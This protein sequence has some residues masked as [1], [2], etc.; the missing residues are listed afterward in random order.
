MSHWAELDDDNVVIR[1]LVGDNEDP[2]GDEGYSWLI[3][4]LGGKWVKTSIHGNIRKVFAGYLYI[5][6][7]V[8]DVFYQPH[9]YG[10]VDY[11]HTLCYFTKINE[12]GLVVQIDTISKNQIDMNDQ[13]QSGIEIL[14][15]KYGEIFTWKQ[16]K[17]NPLFRKNFA[18]VGF[19]YDAELD[20][21]IPPKP[22][23]DNDYNWTFDN[24]EYRWV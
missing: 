16:T 23:E 3:E 13:E 17:Y 6:N 5:Y 24:S 12:D 14:N 2:A 19:T 10:T 18:Q 21:F 22:L 7:E 4:N 8:L 1:V 9:H 15:N 11:D 20:A